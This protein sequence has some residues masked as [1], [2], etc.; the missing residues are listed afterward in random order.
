M[1]YVS[2]REN[3]GTSRFCDAPAALTSRFAET[4]Q[5]RENTEE[6]RTAQ[7]FARQ[8][9]SDTFGFFHTAQR[10]SQER[11][12]GGEYLRILAFYL[13]QMRTKV[14]ADDQ[15]YYDTWRSS[16]GKIMADEKYLLLAESE[17]ARGLYLA[18]R[19]EESNLYNWYMNLAKGGHSGSR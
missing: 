2:A 15:N 10:R 3:S 13:A 4:F 11:L 5:N 16:T 1:V 12:A 19:A 18:I 9:A 6:T 17:E 8:L 7:D 14:S